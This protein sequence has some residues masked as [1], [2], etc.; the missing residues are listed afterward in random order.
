MPLTGLTAVESWIVEDEKDKTR[1]YGLDVPIGTWMLSMKV[2]NDEVWN[3]YVKSG[4]VKGFSIEGYFADKLERP[5]EPKKDMSKEEIAEAKIEELKQLFS[6]EKVDLNIAKKTQPLMNK[7]VEQ[8]FNNSEKLIEELENNQKRIQRQIQSTEAAW[9]KSQKVYYDA[10]SK[11]RKAA[12]DLGIAP[13]DVDGFERLNRW[14]NYLD[15]KKRD[16]VEDL[17]KHLK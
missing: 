5:N 8:I 10:E 1:F 17:K 12:N 11:I 9:K 13:F 16:L 14:Y 15:G 6:T 3:D 7:P 2:Q 4:K